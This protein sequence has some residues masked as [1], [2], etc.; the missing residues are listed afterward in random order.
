MHMYTWIPHHVKTSIIRR[1]SNWYIVCHYMH[2][3]YEMV[4]VVEIGY[5]QRLT[6]TVIRVNASV[7]YEGATR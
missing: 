3:S 7:I 4:V 1:G 2:R 5:P 6:K